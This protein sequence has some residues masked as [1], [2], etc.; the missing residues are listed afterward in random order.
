MVIGMAA[1]YTDD[2]GVLRQTGTVENYGTIKVEKDDGI[3]MYATGSGSKAINRGNIELSGKR[4]IGMYLD[5]NAIGENYG[6]IKTVPNPTNDGII[7][8]TALNGAVIKNYGT[9]EIKGN[10]NTGIYLVKGKREGADPIVTDGATGVKEKKQADTSKKISGVE[11]KAPGNGTAT[12]IRDGKVV[13]PTYVD[14]TVASAKAPKVRVGSTELDL[15]AS[16]LG[17]LPS[18][19]MASELGMYVDTSGVNYTNPIKGLEKLTNLKKVNLI[20]GT[21]A[22][23]YTTSKNIQVGS[24]ILKPYNDVIT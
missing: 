8:V 13:T 14:T 22:S 12:I 7:G 19:S 11:I 23:R 6:T 21:E 10:N 4:T 1:G 20:F 18:V 17:N 24:N 16:S 9:I 2:N 5:N 15:R 3:G